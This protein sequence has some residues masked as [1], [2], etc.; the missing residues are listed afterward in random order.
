MEIQKFNEIANDKNFYNYKKMSYKYKKEF[1]EFLDNL[2]NFYSTK[3][4][5]FDNNGKELRLVDSK[6]VVD[7]KIVKML[8]SPRQTGYGLK[9]MEK[10]IISTS[11]IENIDFNVDSVKKILNGLVPNNAE[12]DHILGLKKG[13]NFISNVRNKITEENLRQLYEM[14]INDFADKEDRLLKN[15]QYRNDA[16]YVVEQGIEHVGMESS[17]IAEA[18]RQLILFANAEDDTNDLV[19][20]SILHFYFVYI[21]PYF[22]GNGRMA[23]LLHLWFLIQKGYQ[24]ALFVP[25]SSQ[26]C[27]TKKAYYDAIKQVEENQKIS[28]ILDVT[29]FVAYCN[30]EIYPGMKQ[31][32]PDLPISIQYQQAVQDKKITPK[33]AKLWKFVIATYGTEEFSTKMLEKDFGNAA[34]ATIREFVMKFNRLGLLRKTEYKTRVRYNIR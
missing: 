3:L 26:I 34:Y 20:A 23:R 29:P 6:I 21:H 11:I 9:S 13:F 25:F 27:N 10:E 31:G 17:K 16:V 18:M 15:E 5:L 28:G 1:P 7:Q 32:V 2:E 12:E 24:S 33:E 4:P 22:D 8:L 14:A 30:K 19:K